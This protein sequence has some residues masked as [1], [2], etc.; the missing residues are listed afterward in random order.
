MG[1][2][3]GDI[4]VARKLYNDPDKHWGPFDK[5]DEAKW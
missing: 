1:I 3:D 5:S 4:T 2:T